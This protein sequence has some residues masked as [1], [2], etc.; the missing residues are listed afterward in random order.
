MEIRRKSCIWEVDDARQTPALPGD[1]FPE[2][3]GLAREEVGQTHP[4]GAA[5]ALLSQL[6]VK[7]NG[8]AR[9]RRQGTGL[10]LET[11]GE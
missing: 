5:R 6:I 9:G 11:P 10:G 7:I 4:V 3:K 1:G 2:K 8:A